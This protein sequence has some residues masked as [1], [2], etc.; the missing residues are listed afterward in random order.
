VRRAARVAAALALVLA[1]VNAGSAT[2]IVALRQHDHLY[3]ATDSKVAGPRSEGQTCKIVQGKHC[4]FSTMGP[5]RPGFD[6][7]AIG[8]AAC[9]QGGDADAQLD[10]FLALARKPLLAWHKRAEREWP[11]LT[12]RLRGLEVLLIGWRGRGVVALEG[13]WRVESGGDLVATPRTELVNGALLRNDE[14]FAALQRRHPVGLRQLPPPYLV[15][16]L[17]EAMMPTYPEVGP[18]VSVLTIDAAG[19]ATWLQPG[20]C[21]QLDPKLWP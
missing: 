10:R 3:I 18:P 20:E 12:H 16:S 8:A 9:A 4:L 21:P 15:R 14:A 7:P 11:A 17:V 2:S 5:W 1:S 6:A 13:G 19:R